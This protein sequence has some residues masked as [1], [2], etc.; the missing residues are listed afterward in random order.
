MIL[1]AALAASPSPVADFQRCVNA[2]SHLEG[3]AVRAEAQSGAT[4]ATAILTVRSSTSAGLEVIAPQEGGHGAVDWRYEVRGRSLLGYDFN[5]G[6]YVKRSFDRPLAAVGT[7]ADTLG[8]LIPDPMLKVM[9]LTQLAAFFTR[10]TGLKG[11]TTS[12]AGD[13]KTWVEKS[14]KGGVRFVFD[15]R[16]GRLEEWSISGAGAT[17]LW[18]FSYPRLSSIPP[19]SIPSDA[20]KLESFRLPP[21]RPIYEDPTTQTLVNSCYQA[22]ERMSKVGVSITE[23]GQTIRVWRDGGTITEVG[24]SGGWRWDGKV[25]NVWPKGGGV[26]RGSIAP[27]DVRS[28]L[29]QFK[30][31]MQPIALAFARD[32]NY[33]ATIITTQYGA[34]MVGDVV[35]NGVSQRVLQLFGPA[36]KVDLGIDDKGLIRRIDSTAYNAA[37]KA[38]AETVRVLDYASTGDAARP[39]AGKTKP[40]PKLKQTPKL[41]LRH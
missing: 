24:P 12:T 32:E 13:E 21:E 2:M 22:Y 23:T 28:Y 41:R 31:D 19:L 16:N 14:K 9:K 35:L 38:L 25:L 10:F 36:V 18:K 1:F 37:G 30:V 15:R 17:V 6:S 11:W 40:M 7:L 34:K 29:G 8:T 4:S 33:A 5:R 20:I 39:P 26:Y 27:S 3:S